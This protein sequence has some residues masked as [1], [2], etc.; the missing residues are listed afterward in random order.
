MHERDPINFDFRVVVLLTALITNPDLLHEYVVGAKLDSDDPKKWCALIQLGF[1]P[2]LLGDVLF[3][4]L[5]R[6]VANAMLVIQ[7][8]YRTMEAV[9]QYCEETCPDEDWLSRYMVSTRQ[10]PQPLKPAGV[11]IG[12]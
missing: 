10:I 8:L 11:E 12:S 7:R 4:F 6:D 3:L 9:V 2:D 1:S 5:R